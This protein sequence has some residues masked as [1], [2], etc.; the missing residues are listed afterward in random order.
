MGG[1]K[2]NPRLTKNNN[3]SLKGANTMC[4]PFR[5]DIIG[6]ILSRRFTPTAIQIM[7][8]STDGSAIAAAMSSACVAARDW[9]SEYRMVENMTML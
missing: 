1:A 5:V 3:S 4:N 6:I 9:A 8:T 7:S 2:R